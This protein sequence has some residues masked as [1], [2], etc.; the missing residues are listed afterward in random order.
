MA[1]NDRPI[2]LDYNAI[3][4]GAPA[5]REKGNHIVT[6]NVEHPAVAKTCD[7]LAGQGF[8]V[9]RVPVDEHGLVDP[10]DVKAAIRSE[11]VLITVMHANNEIGTIEPIREIAA[12]AS[13]HGVLMHTDA[14]QSVGKIP[15]D[16][17]ELGVDLLTIAGHKLYAPKGVG[18]LYIGPSARRVGSPPVTCR[19]TRSACGGPGIGSTSDSPRR[20]KYASTAIRIGDSRTP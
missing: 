10:K 16:V 7:Y 3:I 19:K 8:E 2:Y 14:A 20:A 1:H 12:I 11:T 18:A 13:A 6:S 9:T 17:Q 4:G 15:I 5:R